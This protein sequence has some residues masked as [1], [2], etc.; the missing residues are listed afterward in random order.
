MVN[1]NLVPEDQ[2]S[3][4]NEMRSNREISVHTADVP[5]PSGALRVVTGEEVRFLTLMFISH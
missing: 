4:R 5:K 2:R 1:E 3:G